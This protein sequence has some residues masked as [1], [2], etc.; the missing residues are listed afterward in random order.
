MTFG[1]WHDWKYWHFIIFIILTDFESTG[2]S[3]DG[4]CTG[5]DDTGMR[6]DSTCTGTEDTDSTSTDTYDIGTVLSHFHWWILRLSAIQKNYELLT[7]SVN[8]I[9]LRDA[10]ASKN[11]TFMWHPFKSRLML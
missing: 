9:G 6:S 4:T 8:N 5:T 10:S 11:A 1:I 7:D 2:T 3:T